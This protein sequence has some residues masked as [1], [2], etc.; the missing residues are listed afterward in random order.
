MLRVI[1]RTIQWNNSFLTQYQYQSVAAHQIRKFSDKPE[2][3]DQSQDSEKLQENKLGAFA[4]AFKELD[5][6]ANAPA[7]E[8]VAQAVPFKKLLRNSKFIDVS[9][10]IA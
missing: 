7:K 3:V 4:K 2:N 8:P 9:N 1:L 6:I 10:T 5:E